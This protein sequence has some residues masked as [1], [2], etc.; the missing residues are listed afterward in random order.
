MTTIDGGTHTHTTG[1]VRREC[2][3]CKGPSALKARVEH[4]V[5]CGAPTKGVQHARGAAAGGK[6]AAATPNAPNLSAI[7]KVDD[8]V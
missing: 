7:V 4:G 5:G 1:R 2:D 8:D 6:D 3:E